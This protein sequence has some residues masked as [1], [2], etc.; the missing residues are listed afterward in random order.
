M[1]VGTRDT[2]ITCDV[3]QMGYATYWASLYGP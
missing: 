1:E 2:Y 3:S